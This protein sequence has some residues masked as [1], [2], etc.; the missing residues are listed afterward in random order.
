MGEGEAEL[1]ASLLS[2]P[3]DFTMPG[4]GVLEQVSAFRSRDGLDLY[5]KVWSPEIPGATEGPIVVLAHGIESHT[6]WFERTARHLA[7]RGLTTVSIDR[8]GW[9]RSPGPRGHVDSVRE[10][11][12]DLEQFIESLRE[13]EPGRQVFGLGVSLGGL[14]MTAVAMRRPGLLDGV[15]SLVPPIAVIMRPRI[16]QILRGVVH[17]L[18]SPQTLHALPIQADM[19]T[20]E[21][22]IRDFIESDPHRTRHVSARFFFCLRATQLWVGRN[23][24]RMT[25]PMLTLLAEHD[26]II[27]NSGVTRWMGSIP[28]IP[29][30]VKEYK[31]VKHSLLFEPCRLD[32]L[33]EIEAF[34]EEVTQAC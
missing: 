30:R 21:P 2:P 28:A 17:N 9:G 22:E 20:D 34:L 14:L 13:S 31:G 4:M 19:F 18:I 23:P 25:T 8:R 7:E 32:V 24:K 1:S 15:V 29:S 26:R 5:R 27:N 6:E 33:A 12:G 10:I 16:P 3:S 11:T